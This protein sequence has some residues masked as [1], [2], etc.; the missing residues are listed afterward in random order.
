ME[1]P[2]GVNEIDGVANLKYNSFRSP[3]IPCKRVASFRNVGS[4]ITS[5]A[6]V[7]DQEHLFSIGDEKPFVKGDDVWVRRDELVIVY[8]AC[9]VTELVVDVVGGW[10]AG[11][12]WVCDVDDFHGT[13]DASVNP[14]R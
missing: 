10:D 8:F 4:K 14:E 3:V 2:F 9:G 7:Q 11:Q 13:T 1:D 5:G 6:V 12:G